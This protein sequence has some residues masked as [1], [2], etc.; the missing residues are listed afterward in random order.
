[1]NQWY[2]VNKKRKPAVSGGIPLIEV[3]LVLHCYYDRSF[4]EISIFTVIS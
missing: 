1:M 4:Y 2:I 3:S